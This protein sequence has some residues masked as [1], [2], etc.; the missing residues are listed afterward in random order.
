M[1]SPTP[2]GALLQA[3]PS[4]VQYLGAGRRASTVRSLV[5]HVQKFLAWHS[6]AHHSS[7]PSTVQHLVAYMKTRL[8]EPCNR[9]ALRNINRAYEFLE[10][11]CGLPADKCRTK[12]Q[13]YQLMFSELLT[14][15]EPG[16]PVKQAPRIFASLLISLERLVV[17]PLVPPYMRLYGWWLCVQHWGTLRFSDH[18]GISPSSV[19]IV[20]TEFSAVLSRSKTIGRDKKIQ[21]RAVLIH[22]SAFLA[23]PDWVTQGSQL[24]QSMASF[25]RDYLLPTPSSCLSAAYGQSSSTKLDQQ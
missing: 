20:D 18:R 19:K 6:V 14:Q 5:R 4:D 1:G 17:D 9:G 3:Q 21:S 12:T 11:I 22:R 23:I 2:V 24:L 16:R 8:A 15:A 25:P 7:F 13:V 10:E